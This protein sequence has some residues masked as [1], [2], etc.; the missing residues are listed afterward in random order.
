MVTTPGKALWAPL[1]ADELLRR[2]A[3]LRLQRNGLT[4]HE[5]QQ[6]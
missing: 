1:L 5:K 2:I 6:L 3:R 4:R